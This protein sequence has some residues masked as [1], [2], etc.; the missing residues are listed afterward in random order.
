[1][2]VDYGRKDWLQSSVYGGI[3]FDRCRIAR[4]S[5]LIEPPLRKQLA[6]WSKSVL[7]KIGGK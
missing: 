2:V 1:L 7:N 6:S 5:N 3:L 4:H